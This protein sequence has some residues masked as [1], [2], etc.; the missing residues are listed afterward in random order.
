[1]NVTPSTRLAVVSSHPIQYQAP[2]FVSLAR[3][4]DLHVFYC[5]RQDPAAQAAAGFAAPFEWDVPLLDGYAYSWLENVA[6]RPSVDTFTGCD[7]PELADLLRTGGFAGCLLNGWYLKSYVQALRA[8]RRF[9]LTVLMRGDSQL[10]TPRGAIWS[11]AKYWPYRWLLAQVDAHLYVGRANREYLAHYAVPPERLYPALHFVDN[12]RFHGQARAAREAG[13]VERLRS[14]WGAASGATVCLF[15]GKLVERK[16]PADFIDAIGDAAGRGTNV[17]GVV[18]GS[19]PLEEALRERARVNRA[20]V[21]FCGFMNQTEI[22]Q[23]YAA[24]DCLVLPSDGRETWGLVV[25]EAMA[26]GLPALV[27]D[28]VGCHAD[29]IERGLTGM[30]YPVGDVRALS[31]AITW[32]ASRS[33]AD[34]GKMREA[35]LRKVSEHTCDRAVRGTLAAL[36]AALALR[37]RRTE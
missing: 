24:A 35:V 15:A 5:H 33:A 18:V 14:E 9:G 19:G 13:I 34:A 29:L 10:A 4:L 17:L 21:R 30:T 32:I 12:E 7:T 37:T 26:C 22:P 23:Y 2:W 3:H 28:A 27:S 25:N 36:E 20:P 8:C 31:A 16:R 11:L 1:M 6:R